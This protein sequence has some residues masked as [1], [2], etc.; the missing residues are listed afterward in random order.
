MSYFL[1]TYCILKI[2]KQCRNKIRKIT[3]WFVKRKKDTLERCK[4]NKYEIRI[5]EFKYL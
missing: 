3:Y 1:D 2:E 5:S 4:L